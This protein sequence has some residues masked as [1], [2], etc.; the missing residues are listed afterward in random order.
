[1]RERDSIDYILKNR[2]EVFIK[3]EVRYSERIDDGDRRDRR[4]DGEVF[5]A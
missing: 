4:T 2:M 1:M 3:I 5:W